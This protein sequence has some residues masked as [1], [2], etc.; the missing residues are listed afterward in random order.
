MNTKMSYLKLHVS[1]LGIPASEISNMDTQVNALNAAQALVDNRDTRTKLDKARRNATLKTTKTN[2]RRLITYYVTMNLNATP[3]DFSALN[4]PQTA[5][6]PRLPLPIHIPGIGHI[7][8]YDLIV[9]IPFFDALTGKRAKPE[10]TQAIEMYMKVGGDPPNSPDEMT[11]HRIITASPVR[12]AF[13]PEHE[14]Q[15]V[16]LIFRWIGTRGNCGP[17]S[18]IYRTIILR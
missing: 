11:G 2:M 6:R 7:T 16:Y 3:V 4:I 14:F 18:E 17:W 15:F 8:S 13:G 10:G 5:H 9:K 12:I 1:R